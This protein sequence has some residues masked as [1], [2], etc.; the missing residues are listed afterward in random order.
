[1]RK[2]NLT[3]QQKLI[4]KCNANH[5]LRHNIGYVLFFNSNGDTDI[6]RFTARDKQCKKACRYV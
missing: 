6:S 4:K 3:G 1:M 5:V 2:N